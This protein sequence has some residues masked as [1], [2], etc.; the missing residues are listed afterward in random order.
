MTALIDADLIAYRCAASAEHEPIDVAVARVD[1]MMMEIL[2]NEEDYLSFLSGKNNF[3]KE[4]YPQYKANRIQPKPKWL[5]DC[6]DFLCKDYNAVVVDGYEADDALGW[7]QTNE[8]VIYSIDKD[9]LMIPGCH[10]NFINKTYKEVSTLDGIKAF[11]RQMLIGDTVDNIQGVT[12]L[13]KVK[14]GKLIDPLETEEEMFK[15]VF[16][17]YKDEQRFWTNADCLWIMQKEGERFSHRN[18]N[19][20][21]K[22][23]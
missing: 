20:Q 23:P 10:Y 14:A 11:Y 5:Q 15:V 12:G 4:I 1:N 7:N 16:D 19:N 8:T 6:R 17:L 2:L 21:K 22:S 9:L 3:R 13:G 18:E